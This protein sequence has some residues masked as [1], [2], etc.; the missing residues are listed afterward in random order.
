MNPIL[1]DYSSS[2]NNL[3]KLDSQYLVGDKLIVAPVLEPGVTIKQVFI[4]P[5][6]NWFD[7]TD[8]TKVYYKPFG[9]FVGKIN[10]KF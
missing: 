1:F 7:F 2:D 8:G 6:F 9:D 4:P 10:F 3:Y 5:K